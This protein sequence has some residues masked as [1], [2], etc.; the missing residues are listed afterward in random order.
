MSLKFGLIGD[1]KISVRHKAAVKFNGGEIYKIYDPRYKDSKT[2]L[3]EEFFAGLDYVIIC[4]PSFL[5]REQIKLA[6]K[7][8]KKIICEKPMCLPWE[9]FIDDDR[10]N[11]VLQL[12]W[13]D[14]SEKADL[15]NVVMARNDAYFDLWEGDSKLTGGV[16]YHLFIHYIDLALILDARFEGLVISE[17]K[18]IRM[19]DDL[20]IMKSAMDS[21]YARMYNDI[22][23]HDNGVKPRDLFYL[24]WW[25]D[26]N[27]DIYGFGKDLLNKK[28]VIENKLTGLIKVGN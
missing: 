4:S 15:I 10:V 20:D 27:S 19:I 26:R 17:G 6:L 16:L 8:D 22:I 28:I 9:P 1:G 23:N 13:I 14:L 12:R 24:H 2:K 21:L 7:Y 25:I 11:I 5:H 3:D 18:Q